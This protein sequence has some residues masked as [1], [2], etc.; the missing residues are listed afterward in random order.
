MI[1]W[2][3][4]ETRR[5]LA[6]ASPRLPPD[7]LSSLMLLSP[8]RGFWRPVQL[9]GS[10]LDGESQGSE[11]KV[12]A[13]NAIGTPVTSCFGPAVTASPSELVFPDEQGKML[14]RHT[15]LEH[16]LR[17]ACS[18]AGLLTGYVHKCRRHACGHP[19]AA[20]DAN[21]RRCPKS[22]FKH[23]PRTRWKDLRGLTVVGAERI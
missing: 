5:S 6:A 11:G 21:P 1:P 23:P 7:M 9:G 15:T 3:A 2:P 14:P 17:R 12:L 13:W 20:R 8:A 18:R 16:V 4:L 19:E 22:D 10:G